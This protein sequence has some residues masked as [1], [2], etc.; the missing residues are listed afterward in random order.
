MK[1]IDQDE[2]AFMDL[3]LVAG[4]FDNRSPDHWDLF[5]K[6]EEKG[7]MDWW[8]GP[9]SRET[10][11]RFPDEFQGEEIDPRVT[12]RGRLAMVCYRL[13]RSDSGW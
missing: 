2:Y 7:L 6:L 12:E 3:V 4:D 1:A 11:A 5:E 13:S 10:D 8:Y 9:I